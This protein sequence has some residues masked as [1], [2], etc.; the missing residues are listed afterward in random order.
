MRARL[1]VWGT[2][3]F[4]I[5]HIFRGRPHVR[6]MVGIFP[7]EWVLRHLWANARPRL[8][9]PPTRA[10]ILAQQRLF[11]IFSLDLGGSVG[12]FLTPFLVPLGL[13][14]A[15]AVG[16]RVPVRLGISRALGWVIYARPRF[17][18]CLGSPYSDGGR[19]KCGGWMGGGGTNRSDTGLNLSGSWQQGHSAAYNTPSRI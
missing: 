14:R 9:G 8:R 4:L 1:S 7:D 18:L 19:G 16:I 12:S 15:S 11:P 17:G 3:L 5:P 2:K 6:K 10:R 13:L